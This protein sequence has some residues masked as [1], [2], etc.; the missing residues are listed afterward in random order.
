V[1]TDSISLTPKAALQLAC[2]VV[3]GVALLAEKLGVTT[4]AVYQWDRVPAN[5]CL[6]VEHV[7]GGG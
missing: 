1:R 7:T 3:G 6:A 2:D 5:R 4:P